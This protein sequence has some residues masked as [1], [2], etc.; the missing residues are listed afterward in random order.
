MNLQTLQALGI[1]GLRGLSLGLA[2]S[3]NA[4]AAAYIDKIA[5]GLESGADV[6]ADMQQAADLLEAGKASDADWQEV[7]QG[8]KDEAA[9]LHDD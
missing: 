2:L 1:T 7:V 9:R 4:L 6:D 5:N 3:G 8:V